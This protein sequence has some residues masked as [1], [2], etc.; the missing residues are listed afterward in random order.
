MEKG[1]RDGG[2]V[3]RSFVTLK[4]LG[5]RNCAGLR[6]SLEAVSTPPL[7]FP[8]GYIIS[9]IFGLQETLSY[10][11]LSQERIMF[12]RVSSGEFFCV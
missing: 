4:Q 2:V 3:G 5:C 7:G 12:S 6:G 9:Y 10:Y 1:I 11:S 8:I